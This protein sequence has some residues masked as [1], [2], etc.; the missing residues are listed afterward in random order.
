MELQNE[1]VEIQELSTILGYSELRSIREWCERSGI[2]LF[3]LGKRTYT[4]CS[5]IED[6]IQ[7]SISENKIDGQKDPIVVSGK[8]KST[9][10]ELSEAS[11]KFLSDE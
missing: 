10:K 8:T 9:R 7:K 4:F 6:F 3:K 1:L 2:P 11:K 5:Y